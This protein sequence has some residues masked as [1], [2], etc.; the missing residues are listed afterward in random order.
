M[1]YLNKVLMS[2]EQMLVP[3]PIFVTWFQCVCTAII[4]WVAGKIGE[5]AQA[6][7]AAQYQSVSQ[8]EEVADGQ[9]RIQ[10]KALKPWLLCTVS[11]SR[12]SHQTRDSDPSAILGICW[13]DH[14][15]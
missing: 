5:R 7:E 4:C 15:Q 3:A 8:S 14:I 10:P 12:I 1:V 6:M 13:Y 2:N 9:Q 11:Q